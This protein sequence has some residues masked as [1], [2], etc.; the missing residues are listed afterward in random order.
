MQY[1]VG[2]I[3]YI[4]KNKNLQIVPAKV[5]EE[6]VR[7]TIDETIVQYVLGLPDD[8]KVMIDDV[9]DKIFKDI[10][11]LREF[12]LENTKKTV[13]ALIEKALS[14]K[15]QYFNKQKKEQ[16]KSPQRVQNDIKQVIM[17]NEDNKKPIT[18]EEQ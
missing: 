14:D 2:Q 6:I 7:K 3:I 17:N 1:E 11:T 18:K 12:M 15:D 9:D 10:D 8:K 5:N 4:L 16:I 13:E